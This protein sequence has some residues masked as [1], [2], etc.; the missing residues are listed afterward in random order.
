M[1]AGNGGRLLSVGLRTQISAD[2]MVTE[3]SRA[4]ATISGIMW[5]RATVSM[6]WNSAWITDK[7]LLELSPLASSSCLFCASDASV[8]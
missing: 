8:E 2:C 4:G 7:S 1:G 6:D 5:T 3:R